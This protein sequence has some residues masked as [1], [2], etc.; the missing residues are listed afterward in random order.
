MTEE[1]IAAILALIERNIRTS[2]REVEGYLNTLLLMLQ[3]SMLRELRTMPSERSLTQREVLRVLGGLESMAVTDDV[4]EHILSLQDIFDLQFEMSQRLFELSGKQDAPLSSSRETKRNLV[5]FV[6]SRE[7]MVRAATT[8]YIDEVR[9]SLVDSILSGETI[10][11]FD[12]VD[13]PASKVF[14]DI[15]VDLKTSN[16]VYDRIVQTEMAKKAGITNV[17]YAGPRDSRNRPFCAERV[18]NIYPMEVVYTWDNGQG[19]PAHLY[20]GG[21]GCRHVLVPVNAPAT[22]GASGGGRVKDR[23]S[24]RAK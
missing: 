5:V 15:E 1:E 13:V 20:C 18:N 16:S 22:K 3:R 2:D 21:Y 11:D 8:R 17:L 12:L 7:Q 6:N 4:E 24:G 9:Q 23:K 19:I 14:N 10:S